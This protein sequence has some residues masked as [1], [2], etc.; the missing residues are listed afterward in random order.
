MEGY[1][2]K[3]QITSGQQT[4]DNMANFRMD[5]T[6]SSRIHAYLST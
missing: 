4:L 3:M 6:F 5:L 1:V 2:R